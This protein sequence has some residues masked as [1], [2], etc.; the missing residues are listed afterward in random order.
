M[1]NDE[2]PNDELSGLAFVIPSFDIRHF[3]CVAPPGL[4]SSLA[5]VPAADAACDFV[6]TPAPFEKGERIIGLAELSERIGF[7]LGAE[8]VVDRRRRTP[9]DARRQSMCCMFKESEAVEER[10]GSN[11]SAKTGDRN[12][13][14]DTA[15]IASCLVVHCPVLRTPKGVFLIALPPKIKV[16]ARTGASLAM[17]FEA[18]VRCV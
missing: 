15:T 14:T 1:S 18:G 5:H 6:A 13:A 8:I 17:S 11:R 3:P 16:I 7:V 12:N 9:A 10:N 4:H 2:V